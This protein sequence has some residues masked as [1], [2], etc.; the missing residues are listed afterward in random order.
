[1]STE[2][3]GH[4]H[5]AKLL[6]KARQNYE[7][8]KLARILED[9]RRRSEDDLAAAMDKLTII[10]SILSL[11]EQIKDEEI[12]SCLVLY[13]WSVDIFERNILGPIA[14][15]KNLDASPFFKAVFSAAEASAYLLK[16]REQMFL[17]SFKYSPSD[18]LLI[19]LSR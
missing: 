12:A 13:G 3:A 14:T 15:A 8:V 10:V 17:Q 5:L 2:N 16:T 7:R 1:M 4:D 18:A 9:L 19:A 6:D 11:N